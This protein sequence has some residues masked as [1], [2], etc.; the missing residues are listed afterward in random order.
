MKHWFFACLTW[1]T[2]LA[3]G[4]ESISY[5]SLPAAIFAALVHLVFCHHCMQFWIILL[6]RNVTSDPFLDPG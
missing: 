4:D 5:L 6:V 3:V 1:K 2:K